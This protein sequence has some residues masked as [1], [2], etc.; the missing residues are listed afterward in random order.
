MAVDMDY[1][2]PGMEAIFRQGGMP[3][4]DI[5]KA[6]SLWHVARARDQLAQLGEAPIEHRQDMMD[7]AVKWRNKLAVALGL[8]TTAIEEVQ[9]KCLSPQPMASHA[10]KD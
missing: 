10:V 7:E 3:D 6:A 8:L 1:R 9:S 4:E 5:G 2:F